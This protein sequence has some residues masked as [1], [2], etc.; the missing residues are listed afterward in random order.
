MRS[1]IFLGFLLGLLSCNKEQIETDSINPKVLHVPLGEEKLN[2]SKIF[3]K[4]T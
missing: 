2:A 4:I 1:L 3:E